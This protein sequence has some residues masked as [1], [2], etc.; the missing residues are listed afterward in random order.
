MSWLGK[1]LGGGLG[2]ALGGPLGAVLGMAIGH[3]AL[4]ARGSGFAFSWLEQKQSIYF[5]GVFSMLGKL[6]KADGVVTSNEVELIDR[7]MKDNLRLTPDARRLAIEIF[8]NAKDS[9]NR[10]EDYAAQFYDEFRDSREILVSV[11]DLLMVVAHADGDLHQAEERM[12]IAAARIFGIEDALAQ[13][14]GRF[15]GLLEDVNR[16]YQILGCK[17]GDSLA[18]VKKKYRK[19]A[20]EFHPDRIQAKGMPPELAVNAE[21][22]FKEIQH[23]FDVVEKDIATNRGD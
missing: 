6:A 9:P 7:V 14:R 4:D 17:R 10:F 23:A 12:I 18:D 22:R 19:L 11:L 5:T 13:I 21:E 8:N 20:M 2:F 15:G 16:Y 1:I 3:Q